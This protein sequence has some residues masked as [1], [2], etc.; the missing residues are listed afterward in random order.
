MTRILKLLKI[1]MQNPSFG[2][3][4]IVRAQVKFRKNSQNMQTNK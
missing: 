2:K 3:K 4:A 1:I